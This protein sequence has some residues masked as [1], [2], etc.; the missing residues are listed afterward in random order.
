MRYF[1]LKN[2]R[3]VDL[4]QHCA[5]CLV[6]SFDG[7]IS[8]RGNVFSNIELTGG[9]YYLCGVSYPYV[10][11]NNFHLAF[12][13]KK[14][15]KIDIS[16]NGVSCQINDAVELPIVPSKIMRINSLDPHF[17]TCRNW[18][19]ACWLAENPEIL[20]NSWKKWKTPDDDKSLKEELLKE[21]EHNVAKF[22]EALELAK[23][24]YEKLKK[25]Y[26]DMD[27]S[28]L[29]AGNSEHPVQRSLF[30]TPMD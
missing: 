8:S 2:V 26:S 7:R 22:S 13:E 3:G 18:Q 4:S 9:L 25:L 23:A 21:M 17:S 5:K 27:A 11:S 12:M 20:I 28:R 24:G 14:G 19:F 29:A 30:F 16:R 15:S 10:W 6:G 1:W